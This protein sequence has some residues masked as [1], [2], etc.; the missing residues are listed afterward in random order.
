MSAAVDGYQ[1]RH[2][3]MDL[4]TWGSWRDAETDRSHPVTG[5]QPETW[6][7]FEVRTVR[8]ED[9][10]DPVSASAR[11]EPPMTLRPPRNLT[12][13]ARSSSAI[14]LSWEEVAGA[15]GYRLQRKQGRSGSWGGELE[16]DGET[17]HEDGG[18]SAG[19]EYCYRVKAL[20]VTTDPVWSGEACA[21]TKRRA[22]ANFRVTRLARTSATVAW[23]ASPGADRYR[24]YTAVT[25]FP[26]DG[27]SYEFPRLKRGTSYEFT[28]SGLFGET[29]SERS[30]TLTLTTPSPVAP[31]NLEAT[32]G[33]TEVSLSWSP[34]AGA[35]TWEGPGGSGSQELG[36]KVER[37]SPAG[38]GAWELLAAGLSALEYVD[39]T[40]TAETEYE[41]RVRGMIAIPGFTIH[42]PNNPTRTVVT[43]APMRP[44]P[45]NLRAEAV[46]SVSIEVQWE[47]VTGARGYEL[48]WRVANGEWTPGGE[49]SGTRYGHTGLDPGT[50]YEYSVR[51]LAEIA[52]QHS[53]WSEPPAA[54]RTMPLEVPAGL[55]AEAVSPSR[56]SLRW[57]SVAAADSYE[58]ERT[59]AGGA[60]EEFAVSGTSHEDTEL[61][62]E[63]G[64]SYRV[65]S[66]LTR[67]ERTFRSAWSRARSVT[68]PGEMP[69]N[70]QATATSSVTVELSW[71]AVEGATGYEF[72]WSLDGA[73]W[74]AAA[75]AG[76]GTSHEHSR[77]NPE[78]RYHYQVRVAAM[79]GMDEPPWSDPDDVQTPKLETPAGLSADSVT[80]G[81]VTLGWDDVPAAGSYELERTAAGGSPEEFTVMGTSRED[82][83][84]LAETGYSYRVRSVLTR[85]PETFYSE[86]S[87]ALPV[88]TLAAEDPAPQNLRAT[89]VSSVTVELS[90]DAVD[91]AT[92]YEFRWSLGRGG[93][94]GG[95]VGG[96]GDKP[97]APAVEPGDAVP[98]RGSGGGDA[99]DGGTAVE[100]S[101]RRADAEAGDADGSVGR[102]GDRE[103]GDAELG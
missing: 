28:V 13:T 22:P 16:P 60:A 64:Y 42:S 94:V 100:R 15:D 51:A 91:G 80:S 25:R 99:G 4:M 56:V 7:D 89:A 9:E 93:L 81:S 84:L 53:E 41:Y 6:Y 88:R 92:G 75:S 44:A 36:Y 61:T 3:R 45:E 19:V 38:S 55:E 70:L 68:T 63:T 76:S 46:S 37:R 101:G 69:Q 67:L 97:R 50:E 34:G 24:L 82:L 26:V 20:G 8:G 33:A 52:A 83:G 12:A 43:P 66:V 65:R 32:A 74:S 27:T 35:G 10:S 77:L 11:T 21:R 96:I 57:D 30:G 98:L 86:W 73:D 102:D 1:V 103:R 59:P 85:G 49:E 14:G 40:V 2:K 62:A 78:T 5:L 39:D 23:D 79:P 29:E 87:A 48:R 54:E 95:G 47:S 18:L 72:R 17:S 71:D 58:V 90:W 31:G